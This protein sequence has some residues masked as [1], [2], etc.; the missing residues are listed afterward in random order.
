[1]PEHHETQAAELE[2][3]IEGQLREPL[4]VD[5]LGACRPCCQGIRARQS[6]VRDEAAADERE[7]AVLVQLVRKTCEE[8]AGVRPDDD[9]EHALALGVAEDDVSESN[10]AG[11]HRGDPASPIG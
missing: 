8:S 10:Q 3:P 4:L 6:R 2:E 11:F 1:M 9:D 7:P 5:P